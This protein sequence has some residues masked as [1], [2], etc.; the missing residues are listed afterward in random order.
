MWRVASLMG[1]SYFW[2]DPP[3]IF[4][5]I[6]NENFTMAPM[7]T[8]CFVAAQQKP[9][10]GDRGIYWNTCHACGSH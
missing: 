10:N 9:A 2:Q 5:G 8:F 3:H 4:Q 7:G 1:R 6:K